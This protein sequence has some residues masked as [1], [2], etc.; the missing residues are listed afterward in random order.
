MTDLLWCCVQ[1]ICYHPS[2]QSI[3]F[4]GNCLLKS[5]LLVVQSELLSRYLSCEIPSELDYWFST[6]F[7]DTPLVQKENE[8]LLESS[9]SN[10]EI[11]I[12]ISSWRQKFWSTKSVLEL[13]AGLGKL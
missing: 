12:D 13:G 10:K 1:Y 6:T 11:E 5:L 8:D 3:N 4:L 7:S 2:S 9:A